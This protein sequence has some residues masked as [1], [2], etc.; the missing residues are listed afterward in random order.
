MSARPTPFDLVFGDLAEA[1]F[2]QIQRGL[3]GA[4]VD[5][6]D[7]DA[8][9]LR[10]E[11]GALIQQLRPDEGVGEGITELAA[12]AHHAFLFWRAGAM[13]LPLERPALANLLATAPE[14]VP[15]DDPL[16]PDSFYLQLPPRLV[17]AELTPGEPHEPLDGCFVATTG[18]AA[19]RVLGIF[20]LHP[21]RMGFTVAEAAGPAPEGLARAEGTPLFASVLAGGA[22]AGLHSIAGLEELLE[23]GWRARSA[24]RRASEIA[25]PAERR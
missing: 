12:L 10:G 13:T 18:D 17:W 24:A 7:R 14:R 25:D 19:V 11:A 21:D 1:E 22:A 2:P 5:V 23:L 16:V 15:A 20:G 4:K 8:F 9:L 6:R 3:D